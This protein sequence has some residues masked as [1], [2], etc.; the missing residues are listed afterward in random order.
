MQDLVN[1]IRRLSVPFDARA[2]GVECDIV[3]DFKSYYFS[4]ELAKQLNGDVVFIVGPSEKPGKVTIY[5]SFVQLCEGFYLDSCSYFV[6]LNEREAL[7]NNIGCDISK[8]VPWVLSI[9]GARKVLK[10]NDYEYSN[11]MLKGFC[12]YFIRHLCPVMLVKN[13]LNAGYKFTSIMD[14]V[15]PTSIG[16]SDRESGEFS[17]ANVLYFLPYDELGNYEF[18]DED[19]CVPLKMLQKNNCG[20]VGWIPNTN[21]YERRRH[22]KYRK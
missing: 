14:L 21:W 20:A 2:G 4:L 22:K 17:K 8:C 11:A 12:R 1:N 9:E 5:Y 10:D 18:V 3:M 6:S 19:A 15:I 16:A 7:F 13:D